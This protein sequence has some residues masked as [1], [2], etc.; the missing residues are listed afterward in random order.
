[1]PAVEERPTWAVLCFFVPRGE[2]GGDVSLRLLKGGVAYAKAHG[3]KVVEGYPWDTM[4][5]SSTHRGRSSLF[6][7]A[8]FKQDGK[9]WV[10]R[11]R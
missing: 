1:M 3:A 10:R 7:A 11:F 8:G 6:A 2:R 9:R 5:I 4:G